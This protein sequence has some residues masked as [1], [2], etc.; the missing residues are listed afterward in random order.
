MTIDI[1]LLLALPASGKSELRRYLAS[2][3]PTTAMTDLRF[4]PTV[5]L[6]DYPYVHMMRRIAE[7][8]MAAGEAPVFFAS[9]DEPFLDAGDWG[10]L[11][12]LLNQDYAD[13][14]NLPL[15]LAAGSAS[16]WLFSRLDAAR[17]LANMA[18]AISGLGAMT[19]KRL[20]NALEQEARAVFDEKN[21]AVPATL[22]GKTVII[23][24]ARGGPEG[25]ALPLSPPYGYRYALSLLSN[26]ILERAS[27]LYVWVDPEE[28]RRKNIERAMPGRDGDASILHH[29]VPETVMRNDYGTDDLMWLLAEGGGSF[30]FVEK[31]DRRFALPTG[32]FDNRNDLTSFL[33]TESKDWSPF[34]LR[35][36]HREVVNATAGLRV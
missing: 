12:H 34:E 36:L 9:N 10:T 15:A 8:V 19:Q 23:E 27:I 17:A 18:P 7:E 31:Q 11:I 32:V 28:S 29:G 3:E 21:A 13:L 14:S 5:Q 2:L 35:Q 25:S 6:D 16:E 26:E 33:R 4:G 20:A 24:F 1:L 22:E 30:V